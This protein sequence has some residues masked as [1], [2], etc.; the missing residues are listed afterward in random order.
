[1]E[2]QQDW[3]FHPL[4]NE[5]ILAIGVLLDDTDL[6]NG[7]MLVTLGAHTG[8]LWNHHGEDG[9]C[10]GLIDPEIIRPETDQAANDTRRKSI[11]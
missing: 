8:P 9:C 1:M 6:S 7:P 3:A 2:R 11:R 5:D 4:T 10:R